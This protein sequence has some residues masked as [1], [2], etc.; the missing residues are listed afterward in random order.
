MVVMNN[1]RETHEYKA[2]IALSPSLIQLPN[3]ME[4][5]PQELTWLNT[6]VDRALHDPNMHHV[7]DHISNNRNGLVEF[8]QGFIEKT[9]KLTQAFIKNPNLD[10]DE[11]INN[12]LSQDS[13]REF[14]SSMVS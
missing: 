14:F 5:S 9:R 13:L 1:Y 4:I 6:A 10:I 12:V 11:A 2:L 7:R 3:G 8:A